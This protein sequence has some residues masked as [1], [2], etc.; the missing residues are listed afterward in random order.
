M[1]KRLLRSVVVFGGVLALA[2][3]GTE[4]TPDLPTPPDPPPITEDPPEPVPEPSP[5]PPPEAAAPGALPFSFPA[6]GL[7]AKPGQFVLSPS[8]QPLDEA[9]TSGGRGSFIYYGATLVSTGPEASTVRSLAGTEFSMPNA[10]IL[11]IKAKQTASEG[12]I[13]LGHWESGSGLQ[14]AIVVGGTPTAPVVRY[15]DIAYDNPSGWG[16]KDDTF[17]PDRFE[18]LTTAGQIGATVACQDGSGYRHGVLTAESGGRVIVSGFA[19]ALTAFDRGECV[20]L[21]PKPQLSVGQTVQ[22]PVVGKYVEGKVK[23]V[24]MAAG[25][26][27]VSYTWGGG[28][29][30]KVFSVVDV[31]PSFEAP[32]PSDT[33]DPDEEVEEVEDGGRVGKGKTKFGKVGKIKAKLNR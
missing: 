31:T 11:P 25:R 30:E 32:A 27:T 18:V 6:T 33:T 9:L 13:V 24:D 17:K 10:L 23:S 22:V 7:S 4:E 15:L 14:R 16:Q 5:E 3:S 12:D 26:V 28:D 29:E 21:T 8:R 1:S 19:G 20:D 2:C